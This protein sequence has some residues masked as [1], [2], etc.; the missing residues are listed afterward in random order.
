MEYARPS[1]LIIAGDLNKKFDRLSSSKHRT[2]PVLGASRG[3][4]DEASRP[5]A[6]LGAWSVSN[7][8]DGIVGDPS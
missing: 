5:P 6:P 1:G 7:L 3:S 8:G 4:L 2:D